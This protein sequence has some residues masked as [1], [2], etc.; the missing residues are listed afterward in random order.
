MQQ[1]NTKREN[2]ISPKLGKSQNRKQKR[3]PSG[4]L[5]VT[6]ILEQT[7]N[8]RKRKFGDMREPIRTEN[9]YALF[10][11]D[12]QVIIAQDVGDSN[13]MVRTLEKDKT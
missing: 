12:E 13:Y 2:T 5:Y 8:L 3:P 4:L 7:L 10:F 1:S 9:L 11:A 6:Y